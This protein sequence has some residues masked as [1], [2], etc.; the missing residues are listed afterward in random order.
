MVMQQPRPDLIQRT[1][2][3]K[4]PVTI[5]TGFLGSGK[6]T[7]INQILKGQHDRKI[8]VIVNEF[9]EIGIDGQ[10]TIADDREQIVEFNNGCLCCTVRGDLI[11]TLEDLTQRADLDAVLIETTGLA[12]PAPVA[13]TFIVA[14]EIKSKFSLDAFVTVVDAL[15]LSQNLKDSHE[16]QEQIAFADIVLINK[17][18]LINLDEIVNIEHQIRSLNPI[19]K[20]YHTEHSAIDLSLILGTKAFDL[21]AKLEIDPSFLEDLAHEH[22]AAIGSF[23]LTSDR[24]IDMNKFMLWMNDLAQAKGEDLYRTKGLFYAQGFSERVLFQSVR[25]LTSMR[26]DRLWQ[27][28]EPKLTQLVAIGRNLDRDEFVKGFEQ[29]AV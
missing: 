9:G 27:A 21:E 1:T 25:M 23:A 2:S 3:P 19:A 7:L 4:I 12:D 22:D 26:R 15:N 16:A 18:D 6:T 14:D 17:T 11:R 10:I 29:C 5:V 28:D 24:P 8:A 13:S 20:I